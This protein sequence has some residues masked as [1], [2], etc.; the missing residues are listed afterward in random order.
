MLTSGGMRTQAARETR[1][2][3]RK[4]YEQAAL[5]SLAEDEASLPDNMMP[6]KVAGGEKRMNPRRRKAMMAAKR[7]GP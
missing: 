4:K 6:V 7:R 5:C 1:E 3:W 2:W